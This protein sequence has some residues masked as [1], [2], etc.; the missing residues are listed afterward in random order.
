LCCVDLVDKPQK[1][2][3]FAVYSR[4]INRKLKVDY[5][6]ALITC[7]PDFDDM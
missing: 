1:C 4:P 5:M 2:R 3:L 7:F 6:S